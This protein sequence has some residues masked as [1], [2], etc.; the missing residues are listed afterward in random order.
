MLAAE[1][2]FTRPSTRSVQIL[3]GSS[4][5]HYLLS[6]FEL[7]RALPVLQ[8]LPFRK[9]QFLALRQGHPQRLP[10][11]TGDVELNPTEESVEVAV[12]LE[13]L[14]SFTLTPQIGVILLS[15][16]ERALELADRLASA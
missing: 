6:F 14:P 16:L 1:V 4:K 2:E 9:T 5:D 11:T 8:R 15:D 12:D 3:P 10:L 13:P 7:G